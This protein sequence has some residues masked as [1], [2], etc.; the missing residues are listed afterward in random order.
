MEPLV[1]KRGKGAD[2]EENRFLK[3]R[4]KTYWR[5]VEYAVPS[6]SAAV[7]RIL[8]TAADP[9]AGARDVGNAVLVDYGLT[10][11]LLKKAN[12]AFFSLGKRQILSVHHIVVL[13][14]LDVVM[15][16]V[17][18]HPIFSTLELKKRK[19]HQDLQKI[20]MGLSVFSGL[21]AQELASRLDLD[22]VL[23]R[24][25]ATYQGLGHLLLSSVAPRAYSVMWEARKNHRRMVLV[26]KTLTGWRPAELGLAVSRSWNLPGV[27]R[28]CISR[29]GVRKGSYNP[30]VIKFYRL[31]YTCDGLL[32]AIASASKSRQRSIIT[33]LEDELSITVK[34][35]S[36]AVRNAI[37]N[38][39]KEVPYLYGFLE[40]EFLG[41]I[42]I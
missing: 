7:R 4:E 41:E 35:F 20:L 12:S 10:L 24:T 23:A 17:L 8:S 3:L 13:L 9:R 2:E 27:L 25:C 28:Q 38:L 33:S 39:E 19:G 6:P 5:A 40:D 37:S 18:E 26:A 36:K 22:P 14:G 30:K 34:Q 21:V 15:Q 16:V 32:W 42:L 29:K 31:V 11:E 1:L